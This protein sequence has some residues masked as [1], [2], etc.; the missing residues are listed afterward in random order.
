MGAEERGGWARVGGNG[1]GQA[2]G[3]GEEACDGKGWISRR[4][5]GGWAGR[6]GWEEGGARE[7]QEGQ[8]N[9]TKHNSNTVFTY[10]IHHSQ[11][12][13]SI[14]RCWLISSKF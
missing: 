11:F 3:E 1:D 4:W 8:L 2:D 12:I 5:A 7:S 13:D 10:R 9:Y 6:R 14:Y